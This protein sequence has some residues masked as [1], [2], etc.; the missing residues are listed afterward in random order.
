[1]AP[2][3]LSCYH[4]TAHYTGCVDH[5]SHVV[6]ILFSGGITGR[7]YQM[8]V[9]FERREDFARFT[10]ISDNAIMPPNNKCP[11]SQWQPVRD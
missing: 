4:P 1:M 11:L 5:P 7:P 8:D 3:V 9:A 10:P 2:A 6:T